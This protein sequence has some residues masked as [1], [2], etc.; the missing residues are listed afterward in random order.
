MRGLWG[1]GSGVV[2]A[3]RFT[4]QCHVLVTI[5]RPLRRTRIPTLHSDVVIRNSNQWTI[6]VSINYLYVWAERK[7]WLTAEGDGGGVGDGRHG[8]G[9]LHVTGGRRGGGRGRGRGGGASRLGTVAG[10]RAVGGGE[11]GGGGV[12]RRGVGLRGVG[13]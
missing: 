2:S 5:Q 10:D 7:E 13:A 3:L 12:G 4:F 6:Y 9:P 8:A 1:D 11:D